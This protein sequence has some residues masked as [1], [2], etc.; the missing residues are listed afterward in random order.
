M[1]VLTVAA[2]SLVVLAAPSADAAPAAATH[3][4]SADAAC[5][6]PGQVD[7]DFLL[8]TR[9]AYLFFAKIS[10]STLAPDASR[11]IRNERVL[12]S[13][14]YGGEMQVIAALLEEYG[15]TAADPRDPHLLAVL[16]R[17]RG[18]TGSEF[19]VAYAS[20][21]VAGHETAVA[22]AQKE[23]TSGDYDD[24]KAGARR[25]LTLLQRH[26]DAS[27][28]LLT[29]LGVTTSPV[30]TTAADLTTAPREPARRATPERLPPV[31]LP[32]VDLL[33]PNPSDGPG[34]PGPTWPD[35]KFVQAT[36]LTD[37]LVVNLAELATGRS[38]LPEVCRFATTV[39]AAH[40]AVIQTFGPLMPYY[41]V[42]PPSIL[43]PAVASVVQGVAAF[44]A[45]AVPH[46]YAEV[47]VA[48]YGQLIGA[49]HTELQDGFYL[50]LRQLAGRLLPQF[51]AGLALA[52]ELAAATAP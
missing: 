22:A 18:L 33:G 2:T 35:R 25:T 26:L 50:E 10:S 48:V 52:Q 6:L 21:M 46:A 9:Q 15:L 28:Q 39:V 4:A 12:A 7:R 16:A 41:N 49:T 24:V 37:S 38:Q 30:D 8:S 42:A 19:D 44:P 5:A 36:V 11:P 13:I 32:A 17:L 40:G 3:G 27:R 51:E 20:A 47:M 29:D 23:L 14:D 1:A 34:P 45:A 31:V 43:T